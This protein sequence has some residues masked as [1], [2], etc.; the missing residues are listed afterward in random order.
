V[1]AEVQPGGPAA[2]A[3]IVAGDAII[4]IGHQ[5][6]ST[7]DDIAAAL[8]SLSPGQTVPV[9]LVRQDGSQATVQVK[10]GQYPG[11]GT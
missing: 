6:I 7:P 10:L 3:G 8:A 1:V 9:Q 11:R 4:S 2:K 5:S